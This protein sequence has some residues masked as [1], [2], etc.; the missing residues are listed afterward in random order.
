MQL[1]C[2]LTGASVL[3]GGLGAAT[4]LCFR[5]LLI[6][7]MFS[8]AAINRKTIKGKNASPRRLS[9][10]EKIIATMQ[11]ANRNTS[12]LLDKR[13]IFS[14]RGRIGPSAKRDSQR[15]ERIIT[16]PRVAPTNSGRVEVLKAVDN[17][18]APTKTNMNRLKILAVL[19]IAPPSC[20]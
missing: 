1:T 16:G 15:G 18:P 17:A 19:S 3:S 20:A 2:Y 7:A 14:T 12:I 13:A 6:A 11:H 5:C 4:T 10:S 9:V 8:A